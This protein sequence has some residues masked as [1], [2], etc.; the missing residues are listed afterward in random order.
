MEL[1]HTLYTNIRCTK[2]VACRF[3]T[4]QMLQEPRNCL[5]MAAQESLSSPFGQTL[6]TTFY[7]LFATCYLVPTLFV[8]FYMLL[9]ICYLRLAT[10][11]SILAIFCLL[12]A[13]C[14]LLLAKCYLLLATRYLPLA[15][16]YM[17][18]AKGWPKKNLTKFSL[19]TS[20]NITQMI[21]SWKF[22]NSP[23]YQLL[24]NVQDRRI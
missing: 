14:F 2:V 4:L 24:K 20:V 12:F 9:P 13:T 8:S 7:L 10:F 19:N 18:L 1:F 16:L 17:L 22:L 3:S 23:S 21:S 15:T 5:L 11:C 6:L